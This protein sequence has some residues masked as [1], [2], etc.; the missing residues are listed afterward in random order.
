MSRHFLRPYVEAG[1]GTLPES[2]AGFLKGPSKELILETVPM[3]ASIMRAVVD[4]LG[5]KHIGRLRHTYVRAKAFELLCEVIDGL[6]REGQGSD[7]QMRLSWRDKR[8]LDQAREIIRRDCV[9]VPTINALARQLGLNQRKLKVGFK[10][11]FGTPIFQYTQN[12]RLE[13]ALQLLHT[14]E[15]SVREVADA[16]GYSYSKNFTTAFKRRYGVSPKVAL[17]SFSRAP[18]PRSRGT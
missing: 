14:G 4:I 9:N 1:L 15:Y 8:Q 7:T 17:R 12:L 6:V 5:T 16:V 10:Q 11:L 3:T 13:K 18:R 2:I